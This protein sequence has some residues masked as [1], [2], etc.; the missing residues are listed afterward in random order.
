MRKLGAFTKG[1]AALALG[2][3][4]HRSAIAEE[5]GGGKPSPWSHMFRGPKPDEKKEDP[6][7]VARVRAQRKKADLRRAYSDVL[8]REAVCDRIR[9]IASQTGDMEALKLADV[10]WERAWAVYDKKMGQPAAG[11][12]GG[13][14]A[15]GFAVGGDLLPRAAHKR[16]SAEREEP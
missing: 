2:L 8:R 12:V 5:P 11:Q 9:M 14:V 15:E 1:V 4:L 3:A 16:G 13:F 6:A 7:A 10:L